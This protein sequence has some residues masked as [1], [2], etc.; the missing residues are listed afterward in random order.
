M[1][2]A[3]AGYVVIIYSP[4]LFVMFIFCAAMMV[5]AGG[6]LS[7]GRRV[8]GLTEL[9]RRGDE[10]FHWGVFWPVEI[11]WIKT[12]EKRMENA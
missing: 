1:A 8:A 3:G 9:A 5:E 2:Y 12:D 11:R 7:G 10:V 6:F 4:A